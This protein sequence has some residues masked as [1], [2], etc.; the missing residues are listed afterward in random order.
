MRRAGFDPIVEETIRSPERQAWLYGFGRDYDDGRKIVTWVH[1]S[2][3]TFGL[4][5]D[6]ISRSMGWNAPSKFWNALGAASKDEGLIWGGT[7][8]SPDRPHV[9]WG[10]PMRQA[11][12]PRAAQLVATGGLP[13]LWR[14]VRADG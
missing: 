3:H 5:A 2:W 10:Y 6:I 12:S 9:Q 8:K 4:A 13:A 1:Q 14:E 11:P 7:W